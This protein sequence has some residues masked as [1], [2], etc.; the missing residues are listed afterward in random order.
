LRIPRI[1]HPKLNS[2]VLEFHPNLGQQ[3]LETIDTSRSIRI[4]FNAGQRSD[5][6]RGSDGAKK[7]KYRKL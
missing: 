6:V 2:S 7:K 5:N 3:N 4:A 1:S